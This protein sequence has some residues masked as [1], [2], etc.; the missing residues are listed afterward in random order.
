MY[1]SRPKHLS[2][3]LQGIIQ[4]LLYRPRMCSLSAQPQTRPRYK[5]TD[6]YQ[7]TSFIKCS[8]L[9]AVFHSPGKDRLGHD[10]DHVLRV[11]FTAFHVSVLKYSL[12]SN[13][14]CPSIFN[15]ITNRLCLSQ[16]K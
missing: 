11:L 5:R 15:V 9:K 6:T 3:A 8:R 2:C 1:V 13:T 4:E 10:G 16:S 14:D 7:M 12:R